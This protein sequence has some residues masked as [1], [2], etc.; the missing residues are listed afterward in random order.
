MIRVE[1]AEVPEVGVS[2]AGANI[3]LG[4][5]PTAGVM[6]A[7]RLTVPANPPTLVTVIVDSTVEGPIVVNDEGLAASV[8]SAVPDGTTMTLSVVWCDLGPDVAVTVTV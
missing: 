6:T 5:L 4:A 1:T 3:Q 2:E 7:L 8:K